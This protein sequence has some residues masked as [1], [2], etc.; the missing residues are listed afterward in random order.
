MEADA[1]AETALRSAVYK[2]A[3]RFVPL[4]TISYL[5]GYIDRT[6]L[7]FA[8]LTMN[9]QIGLSPS[10]FGL[11]A[12]IFF[13]GYCLAEMPSNMMLYRFGARR[14]LA[15]I[16]ISWGLVSAVTAFIVGPWS[17][18]SMRVLL[19]VA[20]AGFFPGVTLFLSGWFPPK[21]RTRMLALFL[22][23]IPGSSLIGAPICQLLLQM[24]GILGLAGWQWLFLLTSL[25]CIPL[26]WVVLRFLTDRPADATWLTSEE[27]VALEAALSMEERDRPRSTLWTAIK[28]V[29]LLIS[30][31]IQ[32]G[33]TL[34]S[35]A[36]SIWLPLILK[37]YH[38]AMSLIGWFAAIPYFFATMVMLQWAAS[39]D[40]SGRRITNLE[41]ACVVGSIG[42]L[43][44]L[45]GNVAMILIGFTV[46]MIGI[47]ASRAIFW[48]I[49][50]KFLTGQGAA[51]GLAFINT[52]GTVGGFVGP[53]MI[54]WMRETSGS[55]SSGLI[56]VSAVMF[57]AAIFSVLLQRSVA[58][59]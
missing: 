39:V 41:I 55:Y 34:A 18:Y 9:P 23:G 27:R 42:L 40:F 2:A 5:F 21:Y 56:T 33:F 31:A 53:A 35:Y 49:P 24:D 48:T 25:P 1:R 7:G 32:F 13:L 29:R 6:S 17:F 11:G 26:G 10:Q 22:I 38:L 19:G 12:G 4:L 45:S 47:S 16:M 57:A 8:A 52:L 59:E 51:A 37:D 44:V 3:W 54:G 58:R 43:P 36:I 28:D 15:R 46:S 50:S 30:G 14:W 20:E